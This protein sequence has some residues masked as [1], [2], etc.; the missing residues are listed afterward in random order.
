MIDF[1][2]TEFDLIELSE[3]CPEGCAHCSESPEMGVRHASFE[4]LKVGFDRLLRVES[5][6]PLPLLGN[7]WYP[8]PASDPFLHPE[9]V[10]ICQYIWERRSLPAYL[11][12]LGWGTGRGESHARRLSESPNCLFRLVITISNFSRLASLNR[13]AHV[14]R[15]ARTLRSLQPLWS[16]TAQDG[17]PVVM[18][19]PQYIGDAGQEHPQGYAQ[20]RT[21]L[22]E[23]SKKAGAPLREWED[24]GRV[25]F[26]PI[27]GLGRARTE[28]GVQ[29]EVELNISAELP[30]PPVSR[31][32]DKQFSGM[33]TL[34]GEPAIYCGTRGKLGR[35][36]ADWIECDWAGVIKRSPRM[37]P[38]LA[39]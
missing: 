27:T 18:L 20:T 23:A 36:R 8:F 4:V 35:H 39:G 25:F 30:P 17:R 11:L 7:F 13:A 24:E 12:S 26:R 37:L 15:L 6:M 2:N 28:L 16:S 21:V 9:L 14:T 38:V 31:N 19:S 3:G 34:L 1:S 5:E 33:V 22:E 10:A 29:S 32:R